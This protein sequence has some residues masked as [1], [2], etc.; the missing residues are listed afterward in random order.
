MP[1]HANDLAEV[2]AEAFRL[3]S[4]GVADR[5]SPFRTP[6]IATAGPD[7][8]PSARTM[9]LRGFDPAARRVMLHTDR[10]AG[11]LVNLAHTPR[12]SVHVYDARA[13][14]QVRLSA[15]AQVH[16]D[17]AVARAA[18]GAGVPAGRACYAI[19]PAPGTEVPAPPPAPSDTEAGFANFAVLALTFD[20]LDWLWLDHAGHRRARFAWAADRSLRAAWLVP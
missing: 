11:K 9:V 10:R 13:A 17:D 8:A 16:V 1:A 7:G 2:L 18:W 3:F 14:L 19:S 5:R 12:V 15:L 4:R 20:V 6:T